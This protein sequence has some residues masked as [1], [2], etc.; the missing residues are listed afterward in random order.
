MRKAVKD[1]NGNTW[2]EVGVDIDGK[3]T[4]FSMPNKNKFEK[5]EDLK[6]DKES[7]ENWVKKNVT[8]KYPRAIKCAIDDITLGIVEEKLIFFIDVSITSFDEAGT[9]NKMVDIFIYEFN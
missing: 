1:T 8:I 5:Y 9:E 6:F 2:Y 3:I 4:S 7:I